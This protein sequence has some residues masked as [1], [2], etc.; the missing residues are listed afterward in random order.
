MVV[1][2][3]CAVATAGREETSGASAAIATS[4]K[5]IRRMGF[6]FTTLLRDA[7]KSSPSAW[8]YPFEVRAILLSI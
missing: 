4:K 5:R 7:Q 6:V 3:V 8:E 2:L 1:A